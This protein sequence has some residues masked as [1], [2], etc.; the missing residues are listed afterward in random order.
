PQGPIGPAGPAGGEGPQGPAGSQGPVGPAGPVSAFIGPG[1]NA[2][3][4]DVDL[5]SG[6]PAVT[7]VLTDDGGRSLTPADLEG[8]GFTIAQVVQEEET[9]ITRYQSL[10]LHD[11]EGESF[12]VGGETVEPALASATQSYADSDGEWAETEGAAYIYSFGNELSADINPD[13]TTTVGAYYYKDNRASVANDVFTFVPSGGEPE[14][15]REVTLTENCNGCHDKLALHGGVRQEVGLCITCH[16]NQTID[17]ETGNVLDFRIMIHKIH[18]GELLPSVVAGEPYQIVGFR[19]SVNDYSTVIWPQD[20]RNCTTCHSGGTDSDNYKTMPQTSVCTACHDNV[21]PV[22][23]DNHAGGS[24]DDSE[25]G[26]CHGPEGDEFDASVVGAHVIPDKS[27]QLKGVNIEILSVDNV[28]PGESPILTFQVT[29]NA[30]NV[31]EPANMD[32]LAVTVAGPTSDYTSRETETIFRS[33]SDT[34]PDVEDVGDGAYSYSL[35]FSFPADGT[36]SYGLGMEGYVNETLT[37]LNDPVRVAAFNPVTY[38]ALDSSDP[39]PRRQVVDRDLCNACHNDLALHGGIRQNT[40]YCILCHNTT[41]SDEEVRPAEAMPP[42]SI[43]FRVL[44]HRIHRGEELSQQPLIVYGFNSSVHDYSDVAF[45]GNLANCENCH[46]AGTYG[47]PLPSGIQPT[48]I[49]QGGTEVSSVLPTRS[50]CTACHDTTAASGHTELQ[51]TTSDVETCNVCHGT[52]RDF[53]VY[54]VHD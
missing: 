50:I 22:T 54:T 4:T 37:D 53:D 28:A 46:L 1:L 21:N 30:G 3:I 26:N 48:T 47:L 39:T 15:T 49:T 27:A 12:T 17:P 9:G 38:V 31:I 40:E 33:P 23:G 29:D 16:T 13:L 19:Q 41:A 34:P 11:V 6:K 25:C 20:V 24:R 43:N 32:Y 10:L 51:T 52:G 14:L 7:V 35:A 18:R 8:F 36:G 2:E 45:P 44:I 42:T 5:S